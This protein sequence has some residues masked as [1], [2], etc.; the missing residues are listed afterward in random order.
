MNPCQITLNPHAG[1][2]V[3]AQTDGQ[4]FRKDLPPGAAWWLKDQK[5]RPATLVFV[6]ACGCGALV[7]VGVKPAHPGGWD[8]NGSEDKPTLKPSIR[9]V[10]GCMWH[11]WLTD[12]V[13]TS[14]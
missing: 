7:H 14:C 6:C 13:L 9:R 8:W 4:Q 1:E 2:W 3:D 11:G 12:G 10:A 5:D